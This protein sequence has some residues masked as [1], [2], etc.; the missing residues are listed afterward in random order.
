MPIAQGS[1][2]SARHVGQMT[3][4]VFCDGRDR[5]RPK[6]GTLLFTDSGPGLSPEI[7]KRMFEPFVS[8]SKTGTGLGLSI[9]KNLCMRSGWSISLESN[10]ADKGP[11]TCFS[12]WVPD[13]RE[14]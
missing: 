1:F 5:K 13:S 12:L 10:A 4:L 3:I 2:E 7:R 14:S 6:G 9:V 8:G 11:R